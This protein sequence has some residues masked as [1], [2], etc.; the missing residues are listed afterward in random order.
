M[1]HIILVVTIVGD[2][3]QKHYYA[4]IIVNRSAQITREPGL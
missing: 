2:Q 3:P 4:C 1:L